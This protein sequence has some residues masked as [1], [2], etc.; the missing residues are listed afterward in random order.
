MRTPLANFLTYLTLIMAAIFTVWWTYR[1]YQHQKAR[2][3]NAVIKRLLPQKFLLLAVYTAGYVWFY[4]H[5]HIL[6]FV[7]IIVINVLIIRSLIAQPINESFLIDLKQ[8]DQL[9]NSKQATFVKITLTVIF[10]V[11][12]L[13]FTN[14]RLVVSVIGVVS[15]VTSIYVAIAAR[16]SQ[17]LITERGIVQTPSM[18]EWSD[19]E[20]YL[21]SNDTKAEN[22]TLVLRT[23]SRWPSFLSY[24]EMRIPTAHK[25]AVD[26]ILNQYVHGKEIVD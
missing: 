22:T 23:K 24:K 21:W 8:K 5:E 4:P 11:L 26:N 16:K 15:L 14:N 6:L 20:E 9:H 17:H 10:W 7:L 13:S 3:G 25:A 1:F 12:I 18:I 19:I 2:L